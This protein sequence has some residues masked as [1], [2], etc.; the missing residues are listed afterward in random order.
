VTAPDVTAGDALREAIRH[1]LA[2]RIGPKAFTCTADLLALPELRALI[3]ERDELRGA[4]TRVR[5]LEQA[6][7]ATNA[8]GPVIS[9][10]RRALDGP[11]PSDG[12]ENALSRPRIDAQGVTGVSGSTRDDETV[13]DE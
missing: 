3:A 13:G 2:C 5:E 9:A 6:M 8:P 10:L 4:V 11:T 12:T 7:T 1:A